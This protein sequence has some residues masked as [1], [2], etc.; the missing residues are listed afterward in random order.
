MR[1]GENIFAKI[2]VRREVIATI[3]KH[4]EE[5]SQSISQYNSAKRNLESLKA[6]TEALVATDPQTVQNVKNR[7]LI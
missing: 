6:D 7:I 3:R 4:I 5:C 1:I 2:E